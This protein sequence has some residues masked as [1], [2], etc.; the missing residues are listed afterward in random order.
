MQKIGLWYIN[1]ISKIGVKME[2]KN[3]NLMKKI[4]L[5]GSSAHMPILY[6]M[7]LEEEYSS[8]NGEKRSQNLNRI[9]TEFCKGEQVEVK[10]GKEEGKRRHQ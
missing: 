7:E 6:C 3:K 1:K 9:S 5:H 2:R 10:K 8:Q 4:C